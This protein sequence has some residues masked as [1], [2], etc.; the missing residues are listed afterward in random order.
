MTLIF[1]LAA[2]RTIAERKFRTGISLV[3]ATFRR[4]YSAL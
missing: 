3:L 1:S 2:A 4:K